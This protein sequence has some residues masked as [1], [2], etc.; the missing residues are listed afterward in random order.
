MRRH[1]ISALALEKAKELMAPEDY[2]NLVISIENHK[3]VIFKYQDRFGGQWQYRSIYLGNV[4]SCPGSPSSPSA[5]FVSG[6]HDL[7]QKNKDYSVDRIKDVQIIV[8]VVEALIDPV[9]NYNFWL[10]DFTTEITTP[11]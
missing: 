7:A 6:F 1:V 5:I 3:P 8:T 9:K 10:G 11:L 2:N 4:Y